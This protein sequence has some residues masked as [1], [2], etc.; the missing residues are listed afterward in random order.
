MS[1]FKQS[2]I[3]PVVSADNIGTYPEVVTG[4]LILN[5]PKVIDGYVSFIREGYSS[6]ISFTSAAD[7][8]AASFTVVGLNN[9]IVIS[10]TLTGPNANT[11]DTDNL[12]Q[13]IISISASAD[14][15]EAYTIGSNFNI[16]IVYGSYN[17]RS[18]SN[19]NLNYNTLINSITA[20]NDWAAGTLIVYGVM[21]NLPSFFTATNLTYATRENNYFALTNVDAVTTQANLNS[22]FITQTTYP[23]IGIVVTILAGAN[24]TPAFVEIAQ[25]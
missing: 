17:T 22:G 20:A 6:S 1:V 24:T 14:V 10:E 3:V 23:F 9:G 7:I 19:I 25:N 21:D 18:I 2:V 11:V 12:F 8:S 4:N 5:G 16:A 15:A 13:T